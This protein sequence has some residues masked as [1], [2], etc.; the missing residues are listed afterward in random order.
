VPE[1]DELRECAHCGATLAAEQLICARCGETQRRFPRARCRQCGTVNSQSQLV[2]VVCGEPIR[3]YW[4]QPA[5]IALSILI[6]VALVLVVAIWLRGLG[7]IQQPATGTTE[8]APSE[9]AA[10]PTEVLT[11]TPVPSVTP[12]PTRI[13]TATQTPSPTPMPTWTP[14]QTRSPSPTSTTTPT[15]SPTPTPTST[16]T[17]TSSS[18]PTPTYTPTSLPSPIATLTETVTP[19]PSVTAT[20]F[21][22]IV[23]AGDTLYDIAAR[24][25]TTVES[26]M[27]ANGL[28]ST[29]LSVGQQLTIPLATATPVPQPTQP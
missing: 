26:I 19:T 10:T 2:C 23:E 5:L 7:R 25:G 6:G 24:Y 20:P 9:V 11:F 3:S 8:Q 21:I 13:P 18:T 1:T 22:H 28:T 14:T 15:A 4:I 27:E 12:W 29:R 17:P 16:T